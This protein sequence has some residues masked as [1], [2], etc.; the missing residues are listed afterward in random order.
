MSK[1]TQTFI[2]TQ[3]GELNQELSVLPPSNVEAI[4]SHVQGAVEAF[5]GNVV[6]Q[7][8]MALF[9]LKHG[10]NYRQIRNE[11]VEQKRRHEFEQRIGLVAV[12]RKT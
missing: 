4:V 1:E 7:A 9:D 11:L 12:G 3:D 6:L 8:R 10:T 2:V 5:A